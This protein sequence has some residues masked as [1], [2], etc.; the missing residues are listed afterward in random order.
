MLKKNKGYILAETILAITV[1]AT[2]ITMVYAASLNNYVK[3][4]NN[5]TK[6]NTTNGLYVLS[7]VNKYIEIENIN[8]NL[9]NQN[10][11][12]L[13]NNITAIKQALKID[14]L[15]YC[16]NDLSDLKDELPYQIKDQILNI[17]TEDNCNNRLIVIMKDNKLGYSF[18]V[19][20]DNCVE[21]K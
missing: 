17:D 6:Y 18:A 8:K 20:G 21:E 5:I 15:Y 13:T 11:T 1:V 9:N 19:L 2:A 16:N 14:K 12:D 7:E 10:C 4:D 3:Q